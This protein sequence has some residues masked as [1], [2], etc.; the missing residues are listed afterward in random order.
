VVGSAGLITTI[1]DLGPSTGGR[2]VTGMVFDPVSKDLFVSHS[3]G[4]TTPPE[5]DPLVI[6]AIDP[7]SGT[8]TRLFAPAY[9]TYQ[10]IV[11]GLPRARHDHASNGLAFHDG[12]LYLAQGSMTNAGLPG[13]S[14]AYALAETHRRA[15]PSSRSTLRRFHAACLRRD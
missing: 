10:H 7:L 15:P 5:T 3:D 14:V 12:K 6:A 11:S 4:R 13:A 9:T 2:L 1:Y 8:V